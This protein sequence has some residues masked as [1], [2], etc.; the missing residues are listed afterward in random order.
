MKTT[1]LLTPENDKRMPQGLT[2]EQQYQWMMENL[3]AGGV[4]M[5]MSRTL[6]LMLLPDN[7]EADSELQ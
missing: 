1:E 5:D 7:P 4:S 3:Q 2:W 6:S